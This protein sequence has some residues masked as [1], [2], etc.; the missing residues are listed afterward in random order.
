MRKMGNKIKEDERIEG[1]IRSLL[2]LPENRKCIN[3]N[4][5]VCLL[6]YSDNFSLSG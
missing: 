1:I 3:C 6:Q 5:L 2:K 4:S